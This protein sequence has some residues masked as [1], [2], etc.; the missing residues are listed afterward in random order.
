MCKH[1]GIRIDS[2]MNFSYQMLGLLD[3]TLSK[4]K[5]QRFSIQF[6]ATELFN[7]LKTRGLLPIN[8]QTLSKGE[9]E[10]FYHA[11]KNLNITNIELVKYI[12]DFS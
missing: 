5:L 8:V 11:L 3:K 4:K 6:R 2:K 7:S 10:R 1:L 9:V 12:F